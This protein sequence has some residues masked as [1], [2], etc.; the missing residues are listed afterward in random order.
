LLNWVRTVAPGVPIYAV[1]NGY[2]TKVEA[3]RLKWTGV[4]AGVPDLAIVA[5]GGRAFYLEVK[6]E[7]GRLSESQ[8]DVMALL[9]KLG[10]QFATVTGIDDVRRAFAGW[11]LR[12]GRRPDDAGHSLDLRSR[13]AARSADHMGS[14]CAP[15]SLTVPFC[16]RADLENHH[17]S[18]NPPD[19]VR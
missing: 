9:G 2:R 10:A 19:A 17:E 12:R 6:T 5:P 15:P 16:I 11:V 13:G 1:P 3:A 14:P 8:L 7:T 18:P 4:L